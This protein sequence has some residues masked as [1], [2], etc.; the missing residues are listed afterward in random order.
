MLYSVVS[1]TKQYES[2]HN[3]SLPSTRVQYL[4]GTVLRLA[5]GEL[6]PRAWLNFVSIL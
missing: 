6:C 5:L 2:S 3:S 4:D 1:R